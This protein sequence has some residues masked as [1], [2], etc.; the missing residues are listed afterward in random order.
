MHI[1]KVENLPDSF[2]YMENAVV[3]KEIKFAAAE[4][5]QTNILFCFQ[6]SLTRIPGSC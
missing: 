4:T 3:E 6:Y 2:L 1:L 5:L